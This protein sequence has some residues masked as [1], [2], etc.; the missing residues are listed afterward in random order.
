MNNVLHPN[1]YNQG[2]IE[3][4]DAMEAAFGREVVNHFCL[5]NAFKYLWRAKHKGGDEDIRKA[6]NYLAKYLE[7]PRNGNVRR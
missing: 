7:V 2:D 1:H 3:C 6:L 5:C 4:W